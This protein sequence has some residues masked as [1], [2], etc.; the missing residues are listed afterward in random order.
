[1]QSSCCQRG[2]GTRA[3]LVE[4]V[5]RNVDLGPA[6][7]VQRGKQPDQ[8][9]DRAACDGRVQQGGR[10]GRGPVHRSDHRRSQVPPDARVGRPRGESDQRSA[11]CVVPGRGQARPGTDQQLNCSFA[12]PGCE[13]CQP[14]AE[15]RQGFGERQIDLRGKVEGRDAGVPP[16]QHRPASAGQG[17]RTPAEGDRP[18]A[19]RRPGHGHRDEGGR[20]LRQHNADRQLDGGTIEKR[21]HPTG[22]LQPVARIAPLDRVDLQV[23]GAVDDA[24]H[25]GRPR[26]TG[27]QRKQSNAR[28]RHAASPLVCTIHRSRT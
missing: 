20:R 3:D 4:V 9:R 17:D 1:M 18:A 6:A 16:A 21:Y 15:L 19:D 2:S 26:G 11:E 14:F 24:E 22:V 10:D 28:R 27:Q 23:D 13:R 8:L 25:P 12:V 7:R 5:E